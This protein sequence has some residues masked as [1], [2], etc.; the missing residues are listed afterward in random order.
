MDYRKMTGCAGAAYIECTSPRKDK[1][2][3][4]WDIRECGNGAAEWMETDFGHRPGTEEIRAVVTAWR[5]AETEERIRSGFTWEGCPVWLSAENQMNYKA[6]H[7]LAV[8]T[9]GGT[10]PVTFK[11]GTDG[12]PVYHT[13]DTVEELADFYMKAMAFIQE[14]LEEGWRRKDAFNPDDYR[15]E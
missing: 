10:L 13:F 2:R 14:T 5:N 15:T 12:E 9:D 8:Q 7:D 1:W 6:A 11:F 3:V 4:R